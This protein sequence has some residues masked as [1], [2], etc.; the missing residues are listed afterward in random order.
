MK[1]S[2]VIPVKDEVD[3]MMKTLP[4]YYAIKPS[5]ILICT[6]KPAPLVVKKVVKRIAAFFNAEELTKIVEV[7]RDP[8]WR[9]HQAHVRREGFHKAKYDKILTGDIDLLIN[10]NV[11][12]AL[13][14][15]GKNGVGLASMSKFRYPN[16]F[17]NI[18]ILIVDTLLSKTIHSKSNS[19]KVMTNFTGLYAL[20]KPYWLEIE[21]EEEI[22]RLVSPKQ[23]FR[24]K[25]PDLKNAS[26]IT[27]EDT[28]LRD[29]M[30]KKYN[31]L[32]LTDVGAIDL[33]KN[34]ERLPSIQFMK[35][36][37]FAHHGRSL[38]ITIGRAIMRVQPHYLMGHLS[39]IWEGRKRARAQTG[40]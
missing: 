1:F 4:S 16:N 36:R 32:Y 23:L 8:E 34:V 31:C 3:L 28:F 26:A 38:L 2:V 24:G 33:G 22:K 10:K 14:L 30:L 19:N 27:G 25:K 40:N 18:W 37:Y 11:R 13:N 29:Q 39:V 35:G 15:V 21:T 6:D 17:R 20:W 9:Y 7:E 5:E 12:K